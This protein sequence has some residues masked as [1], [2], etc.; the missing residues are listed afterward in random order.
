MDGSKLTDTSIIGTVEKFVAI[1]SGRVGDDAFGF[2]LG[3]AWQASV[4]EDILGLATKGKHPL[5]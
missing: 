4:L 5:L 1:Y 2:Q 3:T